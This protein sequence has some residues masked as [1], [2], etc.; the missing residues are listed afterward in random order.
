MVNIGIRAFTQGLS[1]ASISLFSLSTALPAQQLQHY[2]QTNLVSDQ[3]GMASVT[4]PNLVN[5]WG[6]SRSSGSP[7]WVSDNGPGL[8]TLYDGTG[9][10]ISLVVATPPADSSSPSGTPTGQIFN[11]TQ[12][13]QIAPGK[14]ALFI[15]STE[16][17][18]I[19]GWNPGVNPTSAVIK[20]N[21]KNAS[22]FKGIA[23]A[24]VDNS[25]SGSSNFLYAADFRKRHVAVY[26]TNFNRVHPVDDAFEDERI[27]EGF[28]PFN[29]QN[30]GGNL[31]VA[32]AKQDSAKHDEV[33]GPGLGY[34]DVF[35]P[36]GRLLH[37]LQ[38]GQWFNGPWGIAQASGDFGIYSHDIL[39]GQFGSGE[40][41][42]FDP[43]TGQ[44]KGKL[45]DSTNM[46]IVIDGL[47]AI[48]FGG[49]T[50][51]APATSLYFTAGPDHEQ[52]GLFGALTAVENVLG[53]DH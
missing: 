52:H 7:W 46:P 22:V 23:V 2:K 45:L 39:I 35:S 21:T 5:P 11:G 48:A 4:D 6:L 33:D 27:P 34:V 29:I 30:I 16:D 42:A 31:Y 37:R 25:S 24:T 26:D 1:L 17:G 49:G 28:A 14:P 15:F 32:F 47:W 20:V 40:I 12:D 10:I 36:T 53:G 50:A 19:S 43:V 9:A 18:T 44:F 8:S 3:P 38:A 13:F 51:T 41:L